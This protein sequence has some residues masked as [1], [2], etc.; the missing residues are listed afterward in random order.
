MMSDIS[1]QPLSVSD[2]LLLPSGYSYLTIA[3]D[4]NARIFRIKEVTN[5]EEALVSIHPHLTYCRFANDF[6]ILIGIS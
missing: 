4:D 5:P 6:C 2:S 3:N 1:D